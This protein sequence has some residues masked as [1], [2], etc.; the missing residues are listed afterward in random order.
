MH[1]LDEDHVRDAVTRAMKRKQALGASVDA[2]L[3]QELEAIQ[4]KRPYTRREWN[5]MRQEMD[6]DALYGMNG[7]FGLPLGQV[8][9][10]I[11]DIDDLY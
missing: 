3:I 9:R 7:D 11:N 10:W 2:Q 8:Y 4:A 6:N 5:I 1:A